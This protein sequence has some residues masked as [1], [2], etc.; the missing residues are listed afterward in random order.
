[1]LSF[2][3]SADS[4]RILEAIS[5]SQ[6]VIQFD[7]TGR[8]LTANE[9]FCR[10]LGYQLKEIVGQHHR[11][12]C[13]PDYAGTPQYREFWARLGRGEY[14]AGAYKRLGQGGREIWIQASYNP[15]FKNGRPYKVVK[16]ATDI[17][18]A[19]RRAQ[20]D[21]S[22]LDAISRSQAVIEFTPTGEILTANENFCATLGYQLSEIQGKHHSMFCDPDYARSGE[23]ADFWKSLA[24]GH[25]NANEFVRYGKGGKEIWIQAAYNPI[26]DLNG[27]VYKVVKFATDVTERMSAITALGGGLKALSAGD[28]TQNIASAFVP[29]M[30]RV[31]KD[32]NEAVA[33]L[34]RAMHAV[35]ENASVIAAG[36]QQIR[37]AADQLSRRT[38][39]Q[40]ASVEETAAA[41]DEITTT[42][43]DSSRR[44]EEAGTLVAQTKDGAERSGDVV[45]SAIAA[46]GQI[47]QS[48]REISNIIGV[49]DDI[50]F[51]TNLLALNAGVEAARAG[52]AGKG[53]AVVAQEVR[54]LAQRSASAAKDIK[55]LITASNGHVRNGVTLVD[56]TGK[57]L[58][59]ILVQV[60]EVNGNVTAI[61]QAA[62]EQ[63]TGLR[64]I[65]QAVNAMDQATQ[66]N[67]AMVEES[68]AA[69]HTM[70]READ[71]LHELLRQFRVD[72]NQTM[73]T[74]ASRRPDAQPQPPS[75]QSP[76]RMVRAGG[77]AAE[78]WEDF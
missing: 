55:A 24:E 4:D 60:Q 30:E 38:E 78:Q 7:L 5:K 64:E 3:T 75:A 1:M 72:E 20:E 69:S 40:A 59:E 9:N 17:T 36:A 58:Q 23:Y 65:N 19:K 46:M 33:K 16:F 41:L 61:V 52:E 49:I 32:F 71:A 63:S 8:I 12:F 2:G 73:A 26:R 47:E 57:A 48:S 62:R 37:D 28:L 53:F 70:A 18:E 76:L 42:V 44:A 56:Q 21:A 77:S 51:Q 45:A 25:F 50:A 11:I 22:K 14:D 27:K 10:A 13:E 6:A 68:T 54:E 34:N 67:A 43:A 74:P 29:S 35:G 31:R 39:Q 15:V 66:Q